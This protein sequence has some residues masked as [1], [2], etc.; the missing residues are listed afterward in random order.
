[1]SEPAPA[2][3][4]DDLIDPGDTVMLM[5][6]IGDQHSSRP[7]TIAEIEGSRLGILVDTTATWTHAVDRGDAVVHITLSDVRANRFV[8]LN[9]TASMSAA[10]ADAERLWNP[11]ARAFFDGVDDPK[12]SVLFFDVSEGEYWDSPNGRIGAL[13]SL[14]RAAL[15]GHDDAGDHGPVA[16]P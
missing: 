11:A 8:A 7:M 9:G 13:V 3:P 12:L 4:L 2:R 5:T 16:T 6:M 15:G 10:R 14:V 1:M